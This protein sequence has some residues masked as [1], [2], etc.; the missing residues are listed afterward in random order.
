[1]PFAQLLLLGAIAGFTVFLG[2][3]IATLR[4]LKLQTRGVL[5]GIATGIL[6]FLT[7]EIMSKA[8]ESGEKTLKD[9]IIGTSAPLHTLA[10]LALLT[11]GVTL[12]LIG[13]PLL[14]RWLLCQ[15]TRSGLPLG[16]VAQA[17]TAPPGEHTSADLQPYALA[18]MISAGIGLHN[19]SEG[20]AIGQ[21]AAAGAA[22]LAWLLIIGFALHNTTEGF[23]I[24]AP[25]TGAR[26]S[27]S[28]LLL[29]GLIAG[30]PTFLG[31]LIGASWNSQLASVLFLSLAGGALLYVIAELFR[32]GHA[33]LAKVPFMLS[34]AFGFFIGYATDLLLTLT[35]GS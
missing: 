19:F 17:A 18:L 3:P 34:V 5:N 29:A 30:G 33:M 26:P 15:W 25:L 11:S 14:E 9:A 12:G 4:R 32:L 10:L 28:F 22:S 31:T 27:P 2:L 35:L 16:I 24:A 7:I 8:L 21:T 23:G 6:I 20:L 13:I 1:M